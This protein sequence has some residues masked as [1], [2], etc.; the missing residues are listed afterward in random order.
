MAGAVADRRSI[1]EG[2]DGINVIKIDLELHRTMPE[3]PAK[4]AQHGDRAG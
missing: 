3:L 4:A 2:V 1:Y